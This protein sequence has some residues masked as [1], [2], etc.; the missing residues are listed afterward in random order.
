MKND[1]KY[2]FK[3][4]VQARFADAYKAVVDTLKS[5]GIIISKDC[6]ERTVVGKWNPMLHNEFG[7]RVNVWTGEFRLWEDGSTTVVRLILSS[8]GDKASA[9][10]MAKFFYKKLKRFISVQKMYLD[11]KTYTNTKNINHNNHTKELFTALQ[12][13]DLK[14]KRSFGQQLCDAIDIADALL[15][16]KKKEKQIYKWDDYDDVS[17]YPDEDHEGHDHEEDGYCIEADE[18]IQDMM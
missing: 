5:Y 17:Y 11:E 10:I 9:K 12:N 7:A 4:I 18:Y 1:N 16:E 15:P 13:T 14:P 8:N 2:I 6:K 3:I